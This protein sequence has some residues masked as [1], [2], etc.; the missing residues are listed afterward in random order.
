MAAT[1]KS[2][3]DRWSDPTARPLFKGRLIDSDGCCCA[4]GD[5]LRVCGWTDYQLR[6]STQLDADKAVAASL[7]ISLSHSV[8]L[9]VVNDNENGCPQDVLDVDGP[10]IVRFLGP[11]AKLVLAFWHHLDSMTKDQW[12]AACNAAC[13]AG[14]DAEWDTSGDAWCDAWRD[15]TWEATWPIEWFATEALAEAVSGA[16]SEVQGISKLITEPY[17]LP[18]FGVTIEQLRILP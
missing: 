2:M 3:R 15:V 11:D 6:L 17:F 4:Q 7:L 10:G 9:R 14:G 13:D 18:M 12:D 5:V 1:L 8:L 16:V